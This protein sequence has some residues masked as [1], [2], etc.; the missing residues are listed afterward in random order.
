MTNT[1]T[2]VLTIFNMLD[3]QNCISEV[4]WGKKNMGAKFAGGDRGNAGI[5]FT[6]PGNLPLQ[7][8]GIM[9]NVHSELEFRYLRR[10]E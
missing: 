1:T 5:S 7:I 9:V 4:R 10:I 3:T 8:S 6:T 2:A